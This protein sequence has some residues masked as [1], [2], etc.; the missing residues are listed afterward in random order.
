MRCE[1]K[2][3]RLTVLTQHK[4]GDAIV[5]GYQERDPE[6]WNLYVTPARW[7][8]TEEFHQA[9]P[10]QREEKTQGGFGIHDNTDGMFEGCE[11]PE[12]NIFSGEGDGDDTYQYTGSSLSLSSALSNVESFAIEESEQE[13]EGIS[14]LPALND[15][16]GNADDWYKLRA[17]PID[18]FQVGAN[19][20]HS[21]GGVVSYAST[22]VRFRR[23]FSPVPVEFRYTLQHYNDFAAS[24]PSGAPETSSIIIPY[25]TEYSDVFE[26]KVDHLSF[27]NA[28]VAIFTLSI[29]VPAIN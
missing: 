7:W 24:I 5:C 19:H 26:V 4:R 29:Y 10:L 12:V 2:Y 9:S 23:Q 22:K 11:A 13:S 14:Y 20:G 27:P 16:W 25:G 6:D 3:V 21:S 15:D 18:S 28:V 1:C 8:E 17:G